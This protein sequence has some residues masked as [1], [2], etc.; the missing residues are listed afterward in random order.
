[1]QFTMPGGGSFILCRHF[2]YELNRARFP[3]FF[4]CGPALSCVKLQRFARCFLPT[5]LLRGNPM[6]KLGQCVLAYFG[7]AA[8]VLAGSAFGARQPQG[9]K[10]YSL[11]P[12][13]KSVV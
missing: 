10:T 3:A 12:D 9:P 1:M 7:A 8:I 11:K 13:R 2:R 5:V 6:K 4:F